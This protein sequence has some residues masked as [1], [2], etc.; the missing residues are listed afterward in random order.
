M[1]YELNIRVY[2]DDQDPLQDLM[3]HLDRAKPQM[4]VINPGQ[5]N[6][7]CSTIDTFI[8]N[9]ELDPHEPSYQLTHWDNCPDGSTP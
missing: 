8:S 4:K 3:E 5:D 9:H 1:F 2:F 7:E 6:Q